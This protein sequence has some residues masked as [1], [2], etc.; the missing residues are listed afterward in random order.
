MFMRLHKARP[1]N[2][3]FGSCSA[4]TVAARGLHG[5]YKKLNLPIA[6]TRQSDASSRSASTAGSSRN[7]QLFSRRGPPDASCHLIDEIRDML[8]LPVGKSITTCCVQR[9]PA[10]P[11]DMVAP[12]E[13]S[14]PWAPAR[15]YF[16]VSRPPWS[17]PSFT[18]RAL[19]LRA[20]RAWRRADR[21]S[22]PRRHR[23]GAAD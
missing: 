3:E 9:S 10:G 23:Q 19:S 22:P 18:P 12:T 14:T 4:P 5:L 20:P 17:P 15:R 6:A 11:P 16:A 8:V 1:R 21:R 7:I 13:S 2:R